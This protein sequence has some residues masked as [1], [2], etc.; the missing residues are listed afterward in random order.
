MWCH[1]CAI[2]HLS[3]TSYTGH[4]ILYTILI[5]ERVTTVCVVIAVETSHSKNKTPLQ[6]F[7]R[8]HNY[9]SALYVTTV[10]LVSVRPLMTMLFEVQT[11]AVATQEY[12]F[13][14]VCISS[15]LVRP[16]IMYL[17]WD[18]IS[19]TIVQSYT[20][21]YHHLVCISSALV[22]PVIMYLKWQYISITIVQGYTGQ[23]HHFIAVGCLVTSAQYE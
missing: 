18:Y 22:R 17:K 4:M 20:G 21:Q 6:Y 10:L 16:V 1:W 8:T 23:Y 15:A 5:E 12:S 11:T 3:E 13:H 7:S 2:F 19:I 14:L 9:S